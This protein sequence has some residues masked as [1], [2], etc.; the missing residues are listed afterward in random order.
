MR[1][2]F[3]QQ[4]KRSLADRV[5]WKCCF[6][7]C[8]EVTIG[9]G[10][11]DDNHV[12]R[13]G[14]AAHINAASP[15]GP[16]YNYD[17]SSE[18]RGSIKNA[19]WLCNKHGE[20]IDKDFTEYSAD[21]LRQWKAQAEERA[22]KNLISTN[23]IDNYLT[24]LISIGSSIICEA[25]WNSIKSNIWTFKVESFIKGNEDALFEYSMN[26][27]V[28]SILDKYLIFERQG[29]GRILDNIEL[30]KRSDSL[31][32]AFCVRNKFRSQDPNLVGSDIAL[33]EDGD[34]SFADGDFKLVSGIDA[35]RQA[36]RL[37]LSSEF[38]EWKEN[39]LIGSYFA[40]HYK[41]YKADQLTLNRLLKLEITR[42][43][44]I[45]VN[46]SYPPSF[47]PQLPFIKR[48][49]SVKVHEEK[50]DKNQ[51]SF[52]INGEWGNGEHFEEI[53]NIFIH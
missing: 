36:I 5:A 35:A 50:S 4:V 32:I 31:E 45:P 39:P 7:G 47:E 3:S 12:V 11:K 6:P 27:N 28:A 14:V 10:N 21:T 18:E 42:L 43:L 30:N 37:T 34:I 15:G 8:G 53:F 44:S 19:I 24:T 20:L 52:L 25:E 9:P 48:I 2:D 49:L 1:D 40:H 51:V 38:G 41:E 17:M 23:E 16:R 26:F 22:H 33:G 29:D 13:L 46:G